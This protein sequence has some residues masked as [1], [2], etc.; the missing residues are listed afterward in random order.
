MWYNQI[1]RRIIID[2]ICGVLHWWWVIVIGIGGGVGSYI[3]LIRPGF[4]IP[5]WL[6]ISLPILGLII[7][8]FL[9]YKGLWVK[10]DELRPNN[11]IETYKRNYRKLPP[12]PSFMSDLVL[13]YSPGMI[14]SRNIQL[15]TPS[16]QFW[17]KLKLDP[18]QQDQLLELAEWLG[19]DRR[20]YLA[21]MKRMAPPG[22]SN[23]RLHR[24]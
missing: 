12:I 16:A 24:K 9:A 7:A 2:Y 14:V 21:R 4:P 19:Q 22:K 13:N 10:Y 17:N 15:I 20:D 1:M 18:S 11:W 23:M 5:S 3:L 8:Q 6:W